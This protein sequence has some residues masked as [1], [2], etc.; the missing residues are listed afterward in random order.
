MTVSFP[1]KRIYGMIGAIR[2]GKNSIADF[3]SETR[4]FM[5]IAF[6][7]QVKEEFGI[8]NADFE[9]A[10]IAGNIEKLREQLWAFSAEKKKEDSQYFISKVIEK[11]SNS[12][13][14]VIITDIRTKEELTAFLHME[15]N[16]F[17][18]KRIYWVRSNEEG[19]FDKN[20]CLAGSKL[21]E[22]TIIN[23][24]YSELPEYDIRCIFNKKKTGLYEFYQQLDGFFFLED[25]KDIIKIERFYRTGLSSYIN[26]FEI[27]QRRKALYENEN[28]IRY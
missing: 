16:Y 13:Q 26:Q 22:K 23:Y 27:K 3:L 18:F 28:I 17:K 24:M 21:S 9:S 15:L 1:F 5:Q 20:R 11:A 6:A 19:E 2:T 14:S 4:G 8:S 7:D 25:I 10:K 12:D